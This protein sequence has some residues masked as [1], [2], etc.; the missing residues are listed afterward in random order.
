MLFPTFLTC[1]AFKKN[2]CLTSLTV[3]FFLFYFLTLILSNY[4]YVI[5]LPSLPFPLSI[6][7]LPL[8]FFPSILEEELTF[9]PAVNFLALS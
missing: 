5:S 2:Y 7:F 9:L 4:Y 3:P 6:S 1:I 8:F